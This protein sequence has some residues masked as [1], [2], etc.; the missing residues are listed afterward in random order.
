MY[1]ELVDEVNGDHRE[2]HERIE[3]E[4][5]QGQPEKVFVNAFTCTLAQGSTEIQFYRG[6]MWDVASPKQ[7]NL[8]IGAM[9][10]VVEEVVEEE[11]QDPC[12]PLSLY[13]VSEW[14]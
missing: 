7:S 8:V 11:Q 4:Q 1:P 2:N 13:D 12:P 5:W 10:T 6:V 14:A 9:E 3:S